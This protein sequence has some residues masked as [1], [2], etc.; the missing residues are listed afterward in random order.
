MP[1]K[2]PPSASAPPSTRS[3]PDPARQRPP[4]IAPLARLG[5]PGL[6]PAPSSGGGAPAP[7][8]AIHLARSVPI[9]GAFAPET[10]GDPAREHRHAREGAAVSALPWLGH[11]VITGADRLAFLEA[12]ATA[13]FLER[14]AGAAFPTAFTTDAGTPV[15]VAQAEVGRDAVVLEVRTDRVEPLL[16]HLRALAASGG[17]GDALELAP[18]AAWLV[19]VVVGPG[20]GAVLSVLTGIA[21][22]TLEHLPAERWRAVTLG[23]V[24][25][26]LRV[27][28]SRL[29]RPAFDVTVGAGDGVATWDAL[30]RG[31]AKPLGT[32]ALE[33]L[34]LEAGQAELVVDLPLDRVAMEAPS[35]AAMVDLHKPAFTGR[36]ALASGARAGSG[37]RTL[38]GL[39][40]L[41]PVGS[42]P[43]AEGQPLGAWPAA[44]MTASDQGPQ[45]AAV[46][47]LGTVA[48]SPTRG[49]IALALVDRQR[50]APG[51]RLALPSGAAA[52]VRALPWP[53]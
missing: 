23:G 12:V 10:F 2:T 25:A 39:E 26:R 32:K 50:A 30:V 19:F 7:H 1:S 52:V 36:E 18:T 53:T 5:S 46:G 11:V 29:G 43:A 16:Q 34:R 35:V 49:L 9:F 22:E 13:R 6:P 38:V 45:G 31:G 27:N 14:P 17:W 24:E 8:V 48:T 33:A 42:P 47:R 41:A 44:P 51:T 20:A 28:D 40:L 15:A 3:E 4:A 21:A 37:A